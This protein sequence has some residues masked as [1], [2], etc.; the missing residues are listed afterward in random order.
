M[1]SVTFPSIDSGNTFDLCAG[2]IKSPV[3]RASMQGIRQN[4][5][6]LSNDYDARAKSGNLHLVSSHKNGVGGVGGADLI[7]N[8]TGRMVKKTMP[9]RAVYD[10]LKILPKYDRCPYCRYGAIETLDHVLP[11]EHYP[12]F[13]VHPSNLVGSCNRCNKGKHNSVPSGPGDSSLH[14]YFDVVDDKLWLIAEIVQTTP[15]AALFRV[16]DNPG[17]DANLEARLRRQFGELDL[18]RLYSDIATEEIAGIE[19]ELEEVFQTGIPDDV[20]AHLMRKSRSR[21]KVIRNSWQAA[22]YDAM[23]T[24]GWYCSG[25]FRT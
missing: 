25:G 10:A 1:W 6:N 11:K 19:E 18:A 22:L 20:A 13:S 14:P 23:A 7:K 3:L 9:A 15:A 16:G 12:A 4:V 24:S 21:R 8:Y 2:R 5:V 17:F